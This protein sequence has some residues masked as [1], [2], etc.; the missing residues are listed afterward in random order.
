MVIFFYFILVIPINICYN[1][2]NKGKVV[3]FN[4]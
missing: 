4:E 2:T 1:N 3:L